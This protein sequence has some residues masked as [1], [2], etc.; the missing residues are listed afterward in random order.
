MSDHIT[1]QELNTH[2]DRLVDVINRGFDGTN[3][4]LDQINGR[5]RRSET[6]IAVLEDRAK[7]AKGVSGGI[8][9]AVSAAVA[10]ALAYFGVGK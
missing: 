10:G 3:E 2:V 6:Q 9:A 1:R 7:R 5:V 8:S 4:R